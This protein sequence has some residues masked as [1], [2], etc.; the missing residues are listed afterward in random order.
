MKICVLADT[1]IGARSGNAV[2]NKSSIDFFQNVCFPYLKKHKIR[3]IIHVGDLFDKR[4]SYDLWILKCWQENFFDVI[5][6]Q[7]IHMDLLVGNHDTLW[8]NTNVDNSPDILLREYKD[9]IEIIIGPRIECFGG[10]GTQALYLPWIVPGDVE[11]A[12]AI[13]MI[14]LHAASGRTT[15][16]F[17]HLEILGFE[18]HRGNLCDHGMNPK[19]FEGFKAVYSGHFHKKSSQGN[20]HYLCP[21]TELSWNE[22]GDPKGFHVFDTETHEMEFIPNKNPLFQCITYNDKD[23]FPDVPKNLD[24]KILKVVVAEKTD[25][26]AFEKFLELIQKQNPSDCAVIERFDHQLDDAA[27]LIDDFEAKDTRTILLETV[28]N[29]KLSNGEA[30]KDLLSTLYQEACSGNKI[31][32]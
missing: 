8:K 19:L 16:V 25:P 17:G 10:E 24:G 30:V 28:E 5:Q 6:Q 27:D 22:A 23:A 15:H 13:D 18:R 12:E 2:I 29:M 21:Q 1:H 31:I 9:N 11:E 32:E 4:K 3:R 14:K 20:I 26:N 7:G